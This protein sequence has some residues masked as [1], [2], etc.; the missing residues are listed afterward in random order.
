MLTNKKI[1]ITG[2]AGFI[3]SNL[4]EHFVAQQ[5]QVVCF[6]NLL[7]GKLENINHLID[8]PNFQFIKGDI[9]DLAACKEAMNGCDIIFH[10]AAL[11]SVSALYQRSVDNQ[12]NKYYWFS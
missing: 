4:C 12:R 5:N 3:G 8:L 1:L 2:G 11:G 10:Q 9:R 7:T 6:D